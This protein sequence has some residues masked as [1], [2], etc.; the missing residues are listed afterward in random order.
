MTVYIDYFMNPGNNASS[1]LQ[2]RLPS[3]WGQSD[4][5]AL[6]SLDVWL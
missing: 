3:A 4:G 6:C 5:A 1:L 2:L